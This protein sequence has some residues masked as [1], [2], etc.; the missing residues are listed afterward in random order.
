[1]APHGVKLITLR[2]C[3]EFLHWLHKNSGV[4]DQVAR[5][6]MTRY[7]NSYNHIS[8]TGQLP[9][10]VSEFLEHVSKFYKK[11]VTTP[12]EKSYIDP[13][14][15]DVTEALLDCIP[16]FLAALY[17]L[18][19]NVDRWFEAVG[20]AKWKYNYPG[21]ETTWVRY[22]WHREYGGR[23]QNY[24]RASLSVKYGDLIAG[25]FGEGEVTYG[26]DYNSIYGYWYG[27][28]MVNDLKAILDKHN[29]KYNDFRDVFFTTVISKTG[30]GTHKVNT[31]NVLA[32][33]KTFCE[34]VAAEAKRG[35]D[36]GKLIKALEREFKSSKKCIN[37][38]KLK[39]HCSRLNSELE[40]LFKIEGFSYTGQARSVNELNTDTFAGETAVWFRNNLHEVQHNVKQINKS[41]PVDDTLY[42]TALRP[43]A[44][45]NIFPYGFI[46]GKDRYGTMGDA[47]KKLSDHWPSVIDMLGSDGD[48][49]DKLKTL[50]DGEECRT[51][52][53]PPKSR[54]RPA[55]A[56]RPPRPVRLPPPGIPR[57]S[58]VRTTGPRNVGGWSS[59]GS[60]GSGARGGNIGARGPNL[61]GGIKGRGAGSGAQK[62]RGGV[63]G[64]R[65]RP[66]A[67]GT[68]RT[69]NTGHRAP[70]HP[71]PLQSQN[72]S[73]SHQQL[74]PAVSSA[75]GGPGPAGKVAAHGVKLDTLKDC[76]RF[77][78]WLNSGQRMSV[79]DEISRQLFERYDKY[80]SFP[81]FRNELPDSLNGFLRNASSLYKQIS[82]SPDLGYYED[83]NANEIVKAFSDCLPKVHAAFSLLLFH[84]DYSYTHVGGGKWKDFE[85]QGNVSLGNGLKM[86]FTGFNGVIDGG[87]SSDELQNVQGKTLAENLNNALKRTTI[88][89][90][91]FT[92][93]LFDNLVKDDWHNLDAGNVLLLLWAFCDYVKTHEGGGDLKETLE[94]ELRSRGMCFKWDDLVKHCRKLKTSL[95]EL[96]GSDDSPGGFST[97]GRAFD[98][99]A[100]KPEA[101]A[102]AFEKWFEKH[103]GDIGSALGTIQENVA[104]LESDPTDFSP[105]IIYP[106]GIVLN[107]HKRNAW[108][109]GLKILPSVLETLVGSRKGLKELKTILEGKGCPA[110]PPPVATKTEATKPVVTKAEAAKPTATKTEGTPNQGKKSEGAQ[111]QGKTSHGTPNHNNG[112]SGDTSATSPVVK[113][114]VSA[115]A[116]GG[117]GASGPPGPKGDKGNTGPQGPLAA[118]TP[119]SSSTAVRT[120]QQPVQPQQPLQPQPQQPPLPPPPPP[121]PGSPGKPGLGGPGSSS[122]VTSSQQPIPPPVTSPTQS[123]SVGGPDSGPAGGKGAGQDGGQD[124]G[125]PTGAGSDNTLSSGANTPGVPAP[126]GGGS[127]GGGGGSGIGH[128]GG[129]GVHATPQVTVKKDPPQHV[130]DNYRKQEEIKKK[131]EKDL[132][133]IM[134][135][136]EEE[137]WSAQKKSFAQDKKGLGQNPP[138]TPRNGKNLQAFNL[139]RDHPNHPPQPSH[140]PPGT[141][142]HPT[143]GRRRLVKQYYELGEER[144]RQGATPITFADGKRKVDRMSLN[145]Q[146]VDEWNW[147][148]KNEERRLASEKLNAERKE[149]LAYAKNTADQLKLLDELQTKAVTY[150]PP[151]P[152]YSGVAIVQSRIDD[153]QRKTDMPLDGFVFEPPDPVLPKAL[154]MT[155]GRKTQPTNGPIGGRIV[156]PREKPIPLNNFPYPSPFYW[157]PFQQMAPEENTYDSK[158]NLKRKSDSFGVMIE[159]PPR[160]LDLR[161][162]KDLPIPTEAL[163]PATPSHDDVFKGHLD[164]SKIFDRADSQSKIDS[165]FNK[166]VKSSEILSNSLGDHVTNK[167]FEP[168]DFSFSPYEGLAKKGFTPTCR[169]PWYV[170]PASS[171]TVTPPLSPL[172]DSDHL[173]PPNTVRE[174]LHWLVGLNQYGYVAIIKK[175]VEGILK[176]LNE[177]VSQSPDALEVTGLPSQLTAAHV[178]NT[179]TEACHYAANVLHR[180]KHKDI[181]QATSIPDFSSEY[182]KLCYSID[183]ACLLCQLRDCVYACYHQLTFLKV[184]CNREQSHGGWKD[185]QYGNGANIPSPLQAFLTDAPDSKFETHPFDPR[186][187]CRKTR[188]NMGFKDEDLPASHETGKHIST[189]LSP[190]CGGDDPLLT[191][192]S[193]LNCLTRRTPRTT[194]ELVSFFHNFGNSLYKPPS[195]LSKL[196]SA[197]SSQHDHCPDWDCLEDADL[198]VIKYVRGSAP[199]SSNSIHDKDHPNTL[200]SL[201]GCGIDNANC[202]QHM[203]PITHRAYALYSKAF[204]HHYLGWTAYLA[205]RLWESLEKLH[206]DLEKLQ[207]HDSMSK[208]LHQCADA[209]P[210]LYRHGITPPDGA[211]QSSLTCAQVI[212]KLEAVVA[213]EPI[214]SLMTAMDTFL[215]GIRAPFLY[216]ITALWLIATLYIL[217]SLLYRMDVLHIRSHLLTTRASH[218]IDVKALLAGSRRMLSL[219]KD[220]DYFDDD[221]H[222]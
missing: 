99:T 13:K 100:L 49:L 107:Q 142:P 171:T 91:L 209:L 65:G 22:V 168:L 115:P 215:Y 202:P 177:D 159:K 37:W 63:P 58:V 158:G 53:P 94:A 27:E 190:S 147:D 132:Q 134:Q 64:A 92:S 17:F 55:P 30:A 146:T 102:G 112:Q 109:Q 4:R 12:I 54:P 198:Q 188:V 180:I 163:P 51:P 84:V 21:W 129:T 48:G 133:N 208:A 50:L 68:Q 161:T 88:T 60:Q 69:R 40:K 153:E 31:A 187:I 103:W 165:H 9:R 44:T 93:V 72:D 139:S 205:D 217:H 218:L 122:V 52:A 201:L 24:L 160:K 186:N 191:L 82:K 172:P 19:Y 213:G 149:M 35:T 83:R 47:W 166:F 7:E 43:F 15:K 113:S 210:L 67:K 23:L 34:I 200:S 29:H 61:R 128:Q 222:S 155:P 154:P 41:F 151:Q 97:T 220:V 26:Y 57:T 78:G 18:L 173:P 104:D 71:P 124:V 77:L 199:A 105:E 174:M 76:L 118:V 28:S 204:T 196:G 164:D 212:A 156:S 135:N 56:P 216:T 207:C 111:N 179:L 143:D 3:F 178:S 46:F 110:E 150:S 176:E 162:P 62:G 20:G 169:N 214:A 5:E 36:G 157:E 137:I 138:K 2:D 131:R 101:F 167:P 6:L 59:V 90:D 219:Y 193:Y 194:G 126:G 182:S 140:P 16:K 145:K 14:A 108:E 125:Q 130:L 89:P 25:G 75:P 144:T 38:N 73:Q 70:T 192:S 8:F 106:Y 211:L 11:L 189:I 1:M 79:R 141:P 120:D 39:S 66:G 148:A 95:D 33:V 123:P 152:N 181:S 203:K 117:H 86:F 42:L 197:L 184:Q 136:A 81:Q 183:P 206:Y 32:L 80:Y 195:G 185:C 87:F 85:T 119:G 74:S 170:A 10:A 98:P 221:F 114:V 116:P 96:F 121:L 175:H 45:K 127:A